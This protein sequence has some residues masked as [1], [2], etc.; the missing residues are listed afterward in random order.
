MS[1]LETLDP[2]LA[3]QIKSAPYL[4]A[5]QEKAFIE[6]WLARKDRKAFDAILAAHGRLVLKIAYKMRHYGVPLSDLFQEGQ[7]GLI[8]AIEKFD[9]STSEA[10]FATYATWWVRA[11]LQE[12][13]M[14]NVSIVRSVKTQERRSLFFKAR[15]VC[16]KISTLH[17]ELSSGQVY[18]RAAQELNADPGE[19]E[20]MV[21]GAGG[22]DVSLNAR[23]GEEE[24]SSE[25]G[26]LIADT[27]A[28]PDEVVEGI[29]DGERQDDVIR[30][31]VS[32]LDPRSQ[33]II[34]SRFLVDE[35]DVLTLEDLAGEYGITRERIRQIQDKALHKLKLS[36]TRLRREKKGEN[37][38]PLSVTP[39]LSVVSKSKAPAP[40][41]QAI[42][43]LLDQGWPPSKIADEL[44]CD[45]SEVFA[46]RVAMKRRPALAKA[47]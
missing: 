45:V 4:T 35:D 13:T 31:A 33:H 44:A 28:G 14:R 37:A 10:R 8:R 12:F 34:R 26:D 39:D 19:V 22:A 1:V 32:E 38:S 43:R 36:I 41:H 9:P 15:A 2:E 23:V 16:A 21:F 46:I 20:A 3:R 27:S 5:D 30:R 18:A 7:V 42:E 11:A 6:A 40:G 24:D 29:I 25:R 47:A 17:P